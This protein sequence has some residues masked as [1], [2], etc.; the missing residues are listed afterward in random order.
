MAVYAWIQTIYTYGGEKMKIL[1]LG[2]G[3]RIHP[4][5]L[6]IDIEKPDNVPAE[7][8]YLEEDLC[9]ASKKYRCDNRYDIIYA[10]YVLEHLDYSC[11]I[12]VLWACY[13]WLKP[14]GKLVIITDDFDAIVRE[15]LA[16]SS[17]VGS[18]RSYWRIYDRLFG[19]EEPG[20][21][22][23]FVAPKEVWIELLE[24]RGFVI[25][26]VKTG[27]GL[28]KTSLLIVAYKPKDIVT[29]QEILEKY[30][31]KELDMCFDR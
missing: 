1:N 20:D 28:R 13:D 22:H 7:V 10:V 4:E 8:R 26:T 9:I 25:D 2:V 27:I 5:A 18:L 3:K 19:T 30:G 21:R 6:N 15:Y 14:G 11:L 23:R 17:K 29:E 24:Q 16:L 12:S 31:F